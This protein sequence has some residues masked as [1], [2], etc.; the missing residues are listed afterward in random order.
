MDIPMELRDLVCSGDCVLFLG[1]GA[2]CDAQGP[3]GSELACALADHF[4]RSDI[5]TADLTRFADILLSQPEINREDVDK[6]I[7]DILRS[8]KPC[9]GHRILPRL[10]V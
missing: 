6:K 1:A 8:L 5:D 10:I 3:S 2:T 9:K 7:V 4:G